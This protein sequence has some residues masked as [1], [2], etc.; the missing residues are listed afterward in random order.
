MV[1]ENGAGPESFQLPVLSLQCITERFYNMAIIKKDT[2]FVLLYDDR[3]HEWD[4]GEPLVS[5]VQAE[6]EYNRLLQHYSPDD[7][8]IVME[9]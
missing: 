3:E 4:A 7:L 1:I 2:W 5:K 8:K 6:L 9:V